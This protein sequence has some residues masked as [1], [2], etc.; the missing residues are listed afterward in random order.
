MDRQDNTWREHQG[1]GNEHP[2]W[3]ALAKTH[4]G[5]AALPLHAHSRG[6]L[7]FAVRGVMLVDA[8]AVQWTVPPQR[9]LWVPPAHPH[10]LRFLSETEMRTVYFR[11]ETIAPCDP[12]GRLQTVH[13]VVA[14]P[15]IRE[16][17]LGLFDAGF[18]AT[19]RDAMAPLLLRALHQTPALPSALPMPTSAPLVRAIAPLLQSHRWSIP[20]RELAQAAGLSERS[21]TR[22]FTQEVGLNFRA[23]RQRARLTASLDLLHRGMA[24]KAIARQVEFKSEAAY[25]TAF[26]GLFKTTPH[27]FRQRPDAAGP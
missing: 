16:L 4:P 20:M 27:A 25:V 14:S 1:P 9:A 17:V 5:G 12:G 3:T 10:A 2:P 21:F 8:G 22:G 7:V 24:V 18:D 19:T 15:L 6:Q 11:P 23:W 13:A 26:R